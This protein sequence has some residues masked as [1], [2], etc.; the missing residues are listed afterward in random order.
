[1][2]LMTEEKAPAS[3]RE[4]PNVATPPRARRSL[5]LVAGA[6]LVL[7]IPSAIGFVLLRGDSGP[8]ATALEDGSL[9]IIQQSE[10]ASEA[11]SAE[12]FL[13]PAPAIDE[14]PSRI[15]YLDSDGRA[16]ELPNGGTIL[17]DNG[18]HLE[19]FVAPYPPT[20][21]SADVDFYLTTESGEPVTD[22]EISITWDMV[23]MTHGPFSAQPTHIGGGHY[24]APFDVFMYGPWEFDTRIARDGEPSANAVMSIYVWPA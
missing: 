10:Q 12:D 3:G 16:V 24:L 17:L 1:V 19:V 22:A 18:L 21:F 9:I 23:F 5:W 7:A 15:K 2:T 6:I 20:D 13:Q 4:P 8:P 14:A 11:G